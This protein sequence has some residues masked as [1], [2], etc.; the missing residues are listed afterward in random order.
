VWVADQAGR[1]D[2]IAPDGSG[3]GPFRW[4]AGMPIWTRSQPDRA[5]PA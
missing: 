3:N 5:P 1:I 2:K 4:L